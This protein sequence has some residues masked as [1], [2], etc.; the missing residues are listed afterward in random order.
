MKKNFVVL[1]STK[2]LTESWISLYIDSNVYN[3]YRY[4]IDKESNWKFI[5]FNL[6]ILDEKSEKEI[7]FIKLNKNGKI[8]SNLQDFSK[9]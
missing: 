8:S 6:N 5:L 4:K 9:I 2:F 1:Y 3:G 7:H